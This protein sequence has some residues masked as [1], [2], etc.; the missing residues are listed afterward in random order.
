MIVNDAL[1]D[2]F[3]M[4]IAYEDHVPASTVI[5]E[6]TERIV[7]QVLNQEDFLEG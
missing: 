1:F 5:K 7:N 6:C 4:V 2:L 3:A